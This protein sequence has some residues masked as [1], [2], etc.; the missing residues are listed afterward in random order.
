M[1]IASTFAFVIFGHKNCFLS[2]L[3]VTPYMDVALVSTDPYT[4][5]VPCSKSADI[6]YLYLLLYFHF[7][8]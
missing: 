3:G 8:Q 2:I 5:R 6:P 4:G 7:I 1:A